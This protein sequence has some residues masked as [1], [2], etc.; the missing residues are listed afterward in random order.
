VHVDTAKSKAVFEEWL[1]QATAQPRPD[2]LRRP[3]WFARAVRPTATAYR[4]H[5]DNDASPTAT[6]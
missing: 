3:E 6:R 4:T 5:H 2:G 1:A